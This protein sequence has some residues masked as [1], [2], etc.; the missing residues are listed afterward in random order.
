ML[1]ITQPSTQVAV[2]AAVAAVE[3]KEDNVVLTKTKRST[4][5]T[6]P[7]STIKKFKV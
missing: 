2:D 4:T 1:Q 5:N 6:K 3:V 7:G